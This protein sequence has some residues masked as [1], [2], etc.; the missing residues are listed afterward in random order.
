M[1]RSLFV[2]GRLK[3][4]SENCPS[5]PATWTSEPT[6]LDQRRGC[7]DR[8][9]REWS[10][11][12]RNRWTPPNQTTPRASHGR[13]EAAALLLRPHR[14]FDRGWSAGLSKG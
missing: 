2:S 8:E 14:S 10:M 5:V 4:A 9:A 1:F 6:R 3:S 7:E 13:G 12:A 11:A